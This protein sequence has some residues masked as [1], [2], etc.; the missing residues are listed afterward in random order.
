MTCSTLGKL[1]KQCS[2]WQNETQGEHS[3]SDCCDSINY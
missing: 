3:I 1:G 2:T